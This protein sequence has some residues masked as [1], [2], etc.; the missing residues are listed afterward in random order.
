MILQLIIQ[1]T[2]FTVCSCIYRICSDR[3]QGI[4]ENGTLL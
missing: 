1:L 3:T 4:Y 2:H